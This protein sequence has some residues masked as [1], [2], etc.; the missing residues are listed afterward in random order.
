MSPHWEIPQGD[1]PHIAEE[2]TNHLKAEVS[3]PISFNI[4]S[5]DVAADT[6]LQ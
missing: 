5:L 3:P 2:Q 1:H 6:N 4:L